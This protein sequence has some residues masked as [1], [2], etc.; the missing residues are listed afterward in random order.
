[1]ILGKCD[2]LARILTSTLIRLRTISRILLRLPGRTVH[3]AARAVPGLLGTAPSA[4]FL[5]AR[6]RGST[7]SR[8]E[9]A[10]GRAIPIDPLGRPV[11]DAFRHGTCEA[12]QRRLPRG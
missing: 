4:V 2:D 12:L 3:M 6:A 11:N 7:F 1:M 5:L 10:P 9:S 8:M